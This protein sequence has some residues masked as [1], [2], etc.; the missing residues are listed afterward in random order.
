MTARVVDCRG[1]A[2]AP[3]LLADRR[4]KGA[5][6]GGRGLPAAAAAALLVVPVAGAAEQPHGW[7]MAAGTALVVLAAVAVLGRHVHWGWL[8][9]V[10][11]CL[12]LVVPR[13]DVPVIG[14]ALLVATALCLVVWL[15]GPPPGSRAERDGRPRPGSRE[16]EAQLVMGMS[17]ER[18]VA[19]M[20][21]RQLPD[22]YV[23]INGLKLPRGA[24]D[25]D[26]LVVGPTDVFLVES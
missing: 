1:R 5:G 19:Q 4:P 2:S 13:G 25:I 12:A 17:G 24:G 3:P 7:A 11:A 14:P 9:V 22:A 18:H 8:T 15:A 10:V 20:L 26:H 21:A 6:G 23:L 16:R